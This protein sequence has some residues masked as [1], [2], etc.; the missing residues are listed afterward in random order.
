MNIKILINTLL[1][2]FLL[3]YLIKKTKEAIH[4]PLPANIEKLSMDFLMDMPPPLL[5]QPQAHLEPQPHPEPSNQYDTDNN[6]ANFVSNVMDLNKFYNSGGNEVPDAT[7]A[8]INDLDLQ[9]QSQQQSQLWNYKN[10][11]PMNGGNILN[12]LVGF[13]SLNDEYATYSANESYENEI[14]TGC[15]DDIR[16]GMGYPNFDERQTN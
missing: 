1:V 11:L 8:A 3:N 4:Y 6:D 7:N 15:N 2:I 13:S 9:S 14:A 10:E 16:M 5:P 12:S